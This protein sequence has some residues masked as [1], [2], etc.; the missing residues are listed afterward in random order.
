[1]RRSSGP[2]VGIAWAGRPEHAHDKD[3][4]IPLAT[5]APILDIP[6]VQFVG[7]QKGSAVVQAECVPE[8]VD[9]V[10]LGPESQELDDAVAIL[11]EVDLLVT[12]DT[13]LAHIAATMGKPVWML[14]GNPADFRW[15]VAGD[16]TP[17]YPTMRLYRQERPRDW[18]APVRRVA[19]DLAAW[20]EAHTRA[21]AASGP[22]PPPASDARSPARLP[23]AE[24]HVASLTRAL[25]MR[26]GF[27]QYDPDEPDLGAV[28]E[29]DGEWLEVRC[30]LAV[31]LAVP[32]GVVIEAAPGIGA[33]SLA[34]ARRLGIDG[35]LMLFE[36]RP[37]LRRILSHNLAA[38]A[39]SMATLLPRGLG[40]RSGTDG[41]VPIDTIDDL[42]L[43][44]LDGVLCGPDA[45]V[46]AILA[47]AEEMLWRARPWLVLAVG[48]DREAD[49]LGSRLRDKG[50]RMWRLEEPLRSPTNFNRRVPPDDD[51][52]TAIALVALPEER[53]SV[54]DVPGAREWDGG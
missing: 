54:I 7:L 45:D 9:F 36:T 29:S 13:A 49:V 44:R 21:V 4:S 22:L 17:W 38:H 20:S 34:L 30:A 31:A 24:A 33:H 23:A 19:A 40:A 5:L 43:D 37:V 16:D 6:G 25:P 18:S 42:G 26:H 41:G 10:N 35:H 48:D 14:V 50:Y 53:A 52:R 39:V 8:R 2:C 1:V 3:R 12:V 47:G 32:G 28:L 15:Q 11:A 46:E 27:L 51:R